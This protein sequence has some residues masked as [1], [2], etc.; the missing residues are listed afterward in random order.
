MNR[1]ATILLASLVVSVLVLTAAASAGAAETV[2][3]IRDSRGEPHIKGESARGAT[4]GFAWAQMQDQA[5]AILELVDHAIGRSA[6]RIGPAC[7]PSLQACFRQDQLAHL[8]RVPE[9][10]TERF[11]SLPQD[12]RERLAAFAAGINAYIDSGAANLP[13]WAAHVTPEEV[14]ASV[15][16]R[17]IMAQ[18]SQVNS[19]LQSGA[20]E[21][22]AADVA[23]RTSGPQ[24]MSAPADR[25]E[26]PA[27]NMF[28]L[29]GSKT[30]SGKPIL[31]GDP[32]LPWDG[33]SRWYAASLSY[34]GTRVQGITFRG[35]PGIA[36][37]S[38]GHLAWSHTANHNAQ[39]EQDAYAEVLNPANPNQYSFA[40]SFRDMQVRQVPIGVKGADGTVRSI[41]VKLRETH[42]GPVLS[43]PPANLNGTQPAPN[44]IVAIAAKVSLYKEALLATQ[45][46][47]A[48]EARTV[49]EFRQA[50][51]L[52]QLSAFNT[53]VADDQGDVFFVAS[54]RSGILKPGRKFNTI[55][56]GPDPDNDWQGILPFSELPDAENPAS[57]Y[58]ENANN[59]P[60]F[61]A[62]DQIRE[63]DLPF[64]LRGGGNTSRSR[65]LVQL[66][67]SQTQLSAPRN[68]TI[69][70]T[71]R[72]GLD[73]YLEFGPSLRELLT[74][75]SDTAATGT[76]VREALFLFYVWPGAQDMSA[77]S[78][79]LAYPMFA[80]WRR[81]LRPSVL[82]F[83]PTNPPPPTTNF[84]P[85]QEAEARR[86]LVAAYD[87]MKAQ[88]G[89][90]VVRYGD[91]HTITWG[92]F[93]AP[94]NGGDSDL[95]TVRMTNCKGQPNSESPIYY[96]PCATRGGS[97]H[98]FD[99]DL[100]SGLFVV[101]R[102]V[103][104]TDEP[105]SPFYTLNARDYAADRYRQFPTTLG[106]VKAQQTSQIT[107]SVPGS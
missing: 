77:T 44:A 51:S 95:A 8:F 105:A 22:D 67:G 28:A 1:I 99:V 91:L 86:A 18:V 7:T 33:A 30:R 101:S 90:I 68:L 42:H 52:N 83:N 92:P 88:Y 15:Q 89:S 57:G 98:I 24:S 54:S 97:S 23:E 66:L 75:A 37:G 31:Q 19:I 25:F 13:P 36:I 78:G 11:A 53:L 40:G 96:H 49:A 107:L 93:S 94:V 6:E 47:R 29:S 103:S 43:D 27:S 69:D 71:K 17:F 58:F 9:T 26:L 82:G 48:S 65:R 106:A 73:T 14:L 80:T 84:T 59:A 3:V 64:Y 12:T 45:Q 61:T 35:L 63:E 104:D 16:Y 87:G 85:A 79:S 76:K 21:E 34:P 4:Y 32:H 55:F 50:L 74:Q 41:S 102:P 72:I 10:A 60:W 62:P 81:G 56:Y 2:R 20:L 70:D 46:G 100:A 5:P 39:H 38:N